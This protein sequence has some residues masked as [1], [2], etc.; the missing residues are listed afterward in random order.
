M[1][2]W[3]NEITVQ[4]VKPSNPGPCYTALSSIGGRESQQDSLFVGE[5]NGSLLAVLIYIGLKKF[6]KHPIMYIAVAAAA[7]IVFQL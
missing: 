3:A 6:K 2:D 4:D 5:L 1:P 7:G